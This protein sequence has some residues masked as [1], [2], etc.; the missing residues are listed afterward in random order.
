MDFSAAD[1]GGNFFRREI[2]GRRHKGSSGTEGSPTSPPEPVLTT[3]ASPPPEESASG[4]KRRQDRSG[5][6]SFL[7]LRTAKSKCGSFRPFAKEHFK[8]N[9]L[10]FLRKASSYSLVL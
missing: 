3:E 1:D 8:M 4:T 7:P 9:L 2:K 6:V 5:Q 10:D